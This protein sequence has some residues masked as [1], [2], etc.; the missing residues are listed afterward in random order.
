[1]QH[2]DLINTFFVQNPLTVLEIG[3]GHGDHTNALVDLGHFVTAVEA[4]D[5]AQIWNRAK[6]SS[7][8]EL[9]KKDIFKFFPSTRKWDVAVALG[10]IWRTHSPYYILDLMMNQVDHILIDNP[11]KLLGSLYDQKYSISGVCL[12]LPAYQIDKYVQ[13]K[14]WTKHWSKTLIAQIGEQ[15][16][17]TAYYHKN[18]VTPLT[19]S[20]DS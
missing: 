4:R 13:F 12:R 16:V 10:L 7:S 1:M 3:P 15:E 9:I 8:V 17:W 14:G 2:I 11:T 19:S 6:I 18:G 5:D 20:L